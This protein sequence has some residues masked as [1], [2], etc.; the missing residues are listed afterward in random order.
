MS[1]FYLRISFFQ[2]F[3]SDAAFEFKDKFRSFAI[4]VYKLLL[5]A[6]FFAHNCDSLLRNIWWR[7]LKCFAVA[8]VLPPVFTSQPN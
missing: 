3:D 4:S 1:I 5:R 6:H 8:I 7:D 2:V